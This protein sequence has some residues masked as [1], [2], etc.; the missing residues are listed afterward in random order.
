MTP[1]ILTALALLTALAVYLAAMVARTQTAPADFATAGSGLPGWA[2]IFA[3]G[4]V[5]LAG[6]D[7]PAQLGLI[8]R[9]G[10]SAGHLALGLVPA[11]LAAV[12]IQKRL[13]LAARITGLSSPGALLAGYYGSVTIR[14]FVLTVAA[15]FALPMAAHLLAGA[16][17]MLAAL[18]QGA[19]PRG[20]AIWALGFAL[21]LPA[22]IGGW[23]AVILSVA[24]QSLLLA[25]LLLALPGFA[26]AVLAGPGFPSLT[27]TGAEGVLTDA[28]PG[29]IQY[30]AGL[31]KEDPQGGIFT[32]VAL[33]SSALAL[34]GLML[35]PGLL[36]LAMTTRPG[37][38][39]AFG[40]V[41]VV[42]GLVGGMLIL[43]APLIV[44]R[45]GGDP[46]V[47]IGQLGDRDLLAG[48]G[49]A[50]LL[51]A[52]RLL[53]LSFFLTAGTILIVREGVLPFILPG[54]DARG[55]R[56]TLRIA[57]AVGFFLVAALA[58][59]SPLSAAVFAPLAAP[60]AVQLFPALLGLAFVRWISRSAVLTGLILSWLVVFF[61]EPPGL[62]LFEG[63]FLDLPWGRW[64][65]TVHSAAW[66]LAVN[67][68]AVLL[69]AIFTRG[70]AER[71]ARDLL[72]D[73]FAQRWK[74]D[75]GGRAARSAKWSLPI[76][77]AFLALGPGAILGNTFFSQP[78]FTEGEAA[79]GLPSLWVWQIL[80]WLLGVPLVWWLAYRT[81][82]GLTTDVG[83]RRVTLPGAPVGRRAAPGWIAASLARV[84]ER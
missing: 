3:L 42:A 72:H 20:V 49:L 77:W 15:L 46:L 82:L 71:Q 21:F 22:V 70:G 31:G 17:D 44:A 27:L 63:L 80:F 56:L 6:I 60:L 57:L 24:V 4:G 79:L 66:G 19:V 9:Y 23:R 37:R 2:A 48:V 11:A 51:L 12:L 68:V 75:F 78:I 26:E 84:T 16:G 28:I 30:S 32:T 69:A 7:L 1:V 67:L 14:L 47:L 8:G 73:E 5:V 65:L 52:S 36:F 64:P 55:D 40:P 13:W 83:L 74:T 76:I 45:M 10:L 50:V 35:S 58:T 59:F 54:L 61:T 53:A 33:A 34:V 25:V 41:W 39:L 43:V 29:V 38:S 81:G 18:T 62:I